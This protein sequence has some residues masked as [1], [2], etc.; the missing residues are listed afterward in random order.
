MELK[1]RGHALEGAFFRD[2]NQQLIE[3]MNAKA[4]REQTLAELSNATGIQDQAALGR[5]ADSGVTAGTLAALVCVP[6]IHVA[7][8]DNSLDAGEKEAVIKAAQEAG[9]ADGTPAAQLLMS[10]LDKGRDEGLFANWTGYIAALKPHLSPDQ[11]IAMRDKVIGNCH[12]VAQASGGI[13]G[14]GTES[15]T[16]KHAIRAV[17]AAFK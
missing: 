13:F 3:K 4:E 14:F 15:G 10:W 17:R 12:A 2:L 6:L 5:L 7:W 16:E 1:D 8:A 11:F 9:V